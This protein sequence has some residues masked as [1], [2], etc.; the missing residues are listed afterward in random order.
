MA[1]LVKYTLY[2][3]PITEA[4]QLPKTPMTSRSIRRTQR[5]YDNTPTKLLLAKIFRANERLAA[6][7]SIKKHVIKG[8]CNAFQDKKKRRKRGK[9]LNLLGEEDSGPQFSSLG[10]VQ[11]ARE[12]QTAK[13]DEETQR[14]LDINEKRR[15][16][17]AKRLLKEKEKLQ[18]AII[19]QEKRKLA[20]EAKVAK[21]AEKQTQ[22]GLVEAANSS[23]K[24][25]V[26][27]QKQSTEPNKV[28]KT[29]K[30]QLKRPTCVI[31]TKEV[32]EVVLTTSTGRRV[33][34]PGRFAS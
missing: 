22:K 23:P 27:L 30:N 8:L 4:P 11:A 24:E 19:T 9:H 16:A 29:Q 17:T 21:A 6:Q 34:R 7:D 14:Q 18:K 31:I 28:Q 20:A 25:Q 10:R 33:Q 2:L 13:E 15:Q 32:D 26:G 1:Q 5:A 3:C 12:F